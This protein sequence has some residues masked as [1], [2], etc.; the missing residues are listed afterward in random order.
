MKK[1][2]LILSFIT[3]IFLLFGC[4]K[5]PVI[6]KNLDDAIKHVATDKT[7]KTNLKIA[8][9]KIVGLIDQ[10]NVSATLILKGAAEVAKDAFKA[11]NKITTLIV[12]EDVAKLDSDAI[13]NLGAL[14]QIYFLGNKSLVG[15]SI[16]NNPLLKKVGFYKTMLTAK[17]NPFILNPNLFEVELKETKNIFFKNQQLLIQDQDEKIVL[18]ILKDFNGQ[19]DSSATKLATLAG[20]LN[21][22]SFKELSFGT[23][24]KLKSIEQGVFSNVSSLEKIS[25]PKSL[26]SIKADFAAINSLK[27]ITLEEGNKNYQVVNNTLIKNEVIILGSK[28]TDTKER[29]DIATIGEAAFAGNITIELT[30]LERIINEHI[31][32]IETHAFLGAINIKGRLDLRNTINYI[33][34]EIFKGIDLNQFSAKAKPGN[35][36]NL[37]W[38]SR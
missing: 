23:D 8:D 27:E 34:A 12:A 15:N 35:L 37:A 25:L 3:S 10:K 17:T 16:N 18:S 2:L 36:Y 22:F 33:D 26:E 11:N 7:S 4:K 30:D 1:I 24:S 14:E 29:N 19:V 13:Q 5:K 9:N 32:R 21:S 31:K 28:N 6:I 20:G 38:N